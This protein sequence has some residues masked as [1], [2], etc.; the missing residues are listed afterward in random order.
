MKKSFYAISALP[1]AVRT[2]LCRALFLT[3]LLCASLSAS[4]TQACEDP[5][6]AAAA[7]TAADTEIAFQLYAY[8]NGSQICP[9]AC[10]TLPAL[11]EVSI[12][13]TQA[14]I[15]TAEDVMEDTLLSDLE[16]FW[17]NWLQAL[18]NQTAQMS[19]SLTD[20]TRHLDSAFDSSDETQNERI[21]EENEYHAKKQ[22][23]STDEG[24]RFDTAGRYMDS[25]MRNAKYV[26][27]G[28]AQS[29][30]QISGNSAA[31]KLYASAGA[32]SPAAWG[33]QRWGDYVNHFC[34]TSSNA[35]FSGCTTNGDLPHADT[36]PGTTLFGKETLD[37]DNSNAAT[38]T[39][40]RVALAAMTYNIT[41]YEAP[42][43]LDGE[44]L[45]TP[46]G[47]EERVRERQYM[48]QMDAASS[49]VTGVIGERTPASCKTGG[50]TC[51][52]GG[53]TP[54]VQA[55]RQKLGVTDASPDA[56]EREIRQ[57]VVEQL[58]DPN[59]WV[60][61]GDSPSTTSE[62]EAYLMAYNL[63]MMYKIVEKTEKI[64][65]VYAIESADMLEK[66]HGFIR[67]NQSSKQP[68]R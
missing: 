66:D 3:A 2:A 54:E 36:Q 15:I 68:Q 55:L 46:Q 1:G 6:S 39:A 41:G 28:L 51:S 67:Y 29:M 61:L 19:G 7:A 10:G 49:L 60:N 27:A 50:T 62:K 5:A 24:C 45:K 4:K 58:W 21:T 40:T 53:A 16:T 47:Q 20:E 43:P 25:N 23:Q 26:S 33:G 13:A 18:K 34:D 63:M 65:T 11:Y 14:A 57:S 31:S 22:F 30:S 35:G 52:G 64:A 38:A 59:Y 32:P 42:E 56:S 37:L 8:F 17:D 12:E 44:V 9:G 48:A